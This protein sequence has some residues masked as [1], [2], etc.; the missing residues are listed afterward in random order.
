MMEETR[1][2]PT[3][4]GRRGKKNPPKR[5]LSIPSIKQMAFGKSGHHYSQNGPGDYLFLPV[6][7][8]TNMM[9]TSKLAE[10]WANT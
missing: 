8:S 1:K 4:N 2:L 7:K 10:E 9:D 3:V 5:N 6:G